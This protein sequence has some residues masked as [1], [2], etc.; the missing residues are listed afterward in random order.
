MPQCFPHS[1]KTVKILINFRRKNSPIKNLHWTNRM[2]FWETYRKIFAGSTK[3]LRPTT[4][5]KKQFKKFDSKNKLFQKYPLDTWKQFRQPNKIIFA[6]N[7]KCFPQSRKTTE[8]FE[9]FVKK[10]IISPQM[11]SGHKNAVLTTT[12]K[13]IYKI[14]N[15]SPQSPLVGVNF[16][17]KNDIV[18]QKVPLN[19]CRKQ[20]FKSGGTLSDRCPQNFWSKLGK[21]VKVN[22]FFRN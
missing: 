13:N 19:G 21:I 12:S 4:K 11:S 15:I 20:F 16:L 7:P 1:P 18:M 3:K 22:I 5:T 2:Q 8:S 10:K 17:D 9:D 14:P 6:K